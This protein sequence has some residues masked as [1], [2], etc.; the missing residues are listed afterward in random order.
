[1]QNNDF[2][3]LSHIDLSFVDVVQS[4]TWCES[5]MA[6]AVRD[7]YMMVAPTGFTVSLSGGHLNKSCSFKSDSTT[8]RSLFTTGNRVP[9]ICTLVDRKIVGFCREQATVF[10]DYNGVLVTH[11]YPD[12]RWSHAPIALGM[13][14]TSGYVLMDNL[15]N[16][17]L[18]RTISRC[19]S[20]V[21]GNN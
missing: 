5:H 21:K 14:L 4:M 3:E 1:L 17:S 10:T 13:E 19:A 6:I 18:R 7:E 12:I 11:E 8:S 9:L 2:I 20:F 15:H 16:F